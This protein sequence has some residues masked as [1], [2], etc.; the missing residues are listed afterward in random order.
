MKITLNKSSLHCNISLIFC[1]FLYSGV[2]YDQIK[3]SIND[4]IILQKSLTPL[5]E[6]AQNK[7][8]TDQ[9]RLLLFS[10]IF[11]FT[12]VK[13]GMVNWGVKYLEKY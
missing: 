4:I 7:I 8:R 6:T 3:L 10:V 9:R 13:L 11:I 2:C 1:S 12:G 5:Y